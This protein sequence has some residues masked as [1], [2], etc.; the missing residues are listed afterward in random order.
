MK[1]KC[2]FERQTEDKQRLWTP[3][4]KT[5]D[6]SERQDEDTTLNTKRQMKIR[7]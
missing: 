7:L 2:G 3:K 6:D 5:K 1:N 4:L